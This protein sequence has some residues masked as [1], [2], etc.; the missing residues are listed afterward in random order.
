[1][2]K[3]PRTLPQIIEDLIHS[4][5]R[6]VMGGTMAELHGIDSSTAV[7]EILEAIDQELENLKTPED[8]SKL[9]ELLKTPRG[10]STQAGN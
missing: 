4:H 3:D 6:Y 8:V 10:R 1:M 9:R 7:N 2:D 5:G